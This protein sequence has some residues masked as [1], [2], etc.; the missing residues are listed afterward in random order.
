MLFLPSTIPAVLEITPKR[1]GD[2]RGYFA[3]IF[4]QRDFEAHAGPTVFV[5]E[6]E[7]LSARVGTIRGLHFQTDPHAQ[8]KLVRCT[9]GAIFDVAV[10]LRSDS[11]TYGQWAGVELSP[12]KGN[13]FWIPPGFAHGFCTLEPDTVVNYKV[14]SH[15][16]PECD[17]GLLW[18]D[19]SV[20]IIW[21]SVADPDTLSAKDRVQP[22]LAELPVHFTMPNS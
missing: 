19:P 20:G 14:T 3:E 6:N 10:D 4:S 11:P 17:K 18:N 13:L 15:Y 16:A 7:S 12:A 22:T 5:Q 1:H 8:G 2:E 21:P 9:A